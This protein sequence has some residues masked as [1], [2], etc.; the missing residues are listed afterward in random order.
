MTKLQLFSPLR[1][2]PYQLKHRV[3]L[4]RLTRMR[5]AQRETS[6]TN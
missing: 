5:A 6:P 1:L 3:I 4:A 2:G